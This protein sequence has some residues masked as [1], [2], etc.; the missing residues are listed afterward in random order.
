MVKVAFEERMPMD[1]IKKKLTKLLP[2]YTFT[3]GEEAGQ[4]K[5]NWNSISAQRDGL[6][7]AID[8]SRV[9]TS[10][11]VKSMAAYIDRQWKGSKS[12]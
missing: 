9:V 12:E 5:E 11:D 6:A 8:C 2:K 10:A 1:K 4:P 7:M 3:T